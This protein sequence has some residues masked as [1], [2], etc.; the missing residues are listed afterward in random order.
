LKEDLSS[1][2]TVFGAVSFAFYSPSMLGFW[3]SFI[4]F[5]A[6]SSFGL[7]V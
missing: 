2:S 7:L 1:G 4:T 6:E 5:A 3:K